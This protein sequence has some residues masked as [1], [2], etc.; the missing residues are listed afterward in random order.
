MLSLDTRYANT[1]ALRTVKYASTFYNLWTPRREA[2]TSLFR[3][4]RFISLSP[5]SAHCILNDEMLKI[6]FTHHASTLR[7]RLVRLARK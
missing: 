7:I 1:T 6:Y 4:F 5:T 2:L 3:C